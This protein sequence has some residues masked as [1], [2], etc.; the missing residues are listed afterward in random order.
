M[1]AAG[2]VWWPWVPSPCHKDPRWAHGPHTVHG[3]G[4]CRY[5]PLPRGNFTPGNWGLPPSVKY[6]QSPQTAAWEVSPSLP[7]SLAGWGPCLIWGWDR[8]KKGKGR[9]GQ[10]PAVV[11]PCR[12]PQAPP[13]VGSSSAVG[14]GGGKAASP[15]RSLCASPRQTWTH[16]G[17]WGPVGAM[18][19]VGR[20]GGRADSWPVVSKPMLLVTPLCGGGESTGSHGQCQLPRDHPHPESP[21]GWKHREGYASSPHRGWAGSSGSAGMRNWGN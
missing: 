4:R 2:G 9:V 7:P 14:A 17:W 11:W 20:R 1:G 21:K 16:R 10:G 3:P 13:G 18:G 15:T 19:P 12:G 5:Q 6:L 8:L